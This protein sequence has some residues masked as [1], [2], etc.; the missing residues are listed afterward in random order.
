VQQPGAERIGDPLGE[1]GR[2]LGRD[3]QAAPGAGRRHVVLDGRI[4]PHPPELG[5]A[6]GLAGDDGERAVEDRSLGL[7]FRRRRDQ[8][9]G[10]PPPDP[11]APSERLEQWPG[12][13]LGD[14]PSAGVG[15]LHEP[16]ADIVVRIAE[17]GGHDRARR[18]Q[19]AGILHSAGGEDERARPDRESA[20]AERS[21]EDPIDPPAGPGRLDRGRR[22]VEEYLAARMIG[23]IG[24]AFPGEAVEARVE[25]PDR[26]GQ[27]LGIERRN[28]NA[29]R[30]KPIGRGGRAIEPEEG[31]GLVIIR[32]ELVVRD[33]PAR[34]G[35]PGPG[36]EVDRVELGAAAAPD[37]RR[38]AE[39]SKPRMIERVIILADILAGVEIGGGRLVIAAAAFEDDQAAAP[40]EQPPGDGEPG[41]AGSDDADFGFARQGVADLVEIGE[42]RP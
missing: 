7:Q 32:A 15:M 22:R 39:E 1:A 34:I 20:A 18:E 38:P 29:R 40:G 28:R 36:L 3:P 2:P 8:G 10:V 24:A 25:A 27:S 26:N 37:R 23:E 11:V 31:P 14:P 17:T 33:R 42:H 9:G 35:D 6:L 30:A 5:G 21:G 12:P 41:R 4:S 19:E 16:A 13:G